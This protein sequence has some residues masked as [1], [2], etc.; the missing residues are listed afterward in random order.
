VGLIA[1]AS[2]TK[3]YYS[4]RPGERILLATDGVTEAENLAGEPL[5]DA[6]LDALA[7]LETL[8]Q[9]LTRVA[10]YQSP[11]EAND[12]CTLLEIRYNGPLAGEDI[13]R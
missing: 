9:I 7:R 1:G 6:G 12:D 5:G 3:A 10:D 2:Y 4:L 11:N 8:D 13:T